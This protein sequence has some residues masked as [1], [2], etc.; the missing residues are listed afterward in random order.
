MSWW[1]PILSS[2][3][4]LSAASGLGQRPPHAHGRGFRKE[5]GGFGG[6]SALAMHNLVDPLD[7]HTN[8]TGKRYL[9]KPKRVRKFLQQDF[10]G[11]GGKTVFWEQGYSFPG[12]NRDI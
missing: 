11:V 9:R 10:S 8:M 7:R 2:V 12:N 5:P 4:I 3:G 6:D 1:D